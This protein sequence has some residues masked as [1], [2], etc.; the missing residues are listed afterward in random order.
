MNT[1]SDSEAATLPYQMQARQDLVK[2]PQLERELRSLRHTVGPV[3][4]AVMPFG[5]G[6]AWVAVGHQEARQVFEDPRFGVAAH[7]GNNYPRMRHSEGHKEPFPISF[8]H[9]D[10][11]EHVAKRR[12]L[13]RHLSVKRVLAMKPHTEGIV[14]DFLHE[15]ESQGPGADIVAYYSEQIPLAVISHLI[16]IPVEDKDYF[17]DAALDMMNGRV[18]TEEEANKKIAEVSSYFG[19][20][21]KQKRDD[22]Q[23]DL[24]SAIVTD[25]AAGKWTEEELEGAGF[26]LLTAGHDATASILGGILYWLVHDPDL[27]AYLRDNRDKLPRAIE[28]F[29]RVIPAGTGTRVRIAYEDVEIGGVTV[30]KGDGIH[31]TVH[32]ANFDERVYTDPLDLIV[33]RDETPHLRFGFGPHGCPGSQ[34]ARMELQVAI[35]AIFD[36]FPRL[37]AVDPSDGWREEVLMRGPRSVH[38]AWDADE[39]RS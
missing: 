32:P 22:P 26:A 3:I 33:D 27:Y 13:T 8:I 38:V 2:G 30:K 12:V 14:A 7:R 18:A 39:A 16:G 10:G 1:H 17:L 11:P 28:E 34:L 25:A 9:M 37:W 35:S 36:R 4:P 24:L 19:R 15:F 21:A 31:P 5:E 20:L 23:D 29:L 6:Q